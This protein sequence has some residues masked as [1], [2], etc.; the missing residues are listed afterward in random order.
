MRWIIVLM[1]IMGCGIERVEYGKGIDSTVAL[2][3]RVEVEGGGSVMAPYCTGV[4]I[5]E[6]EIITAKHCLEGKRGVE[7]I[8]REDM[9]G[10]YKEP[11]RV[12]KGRV[13]YM[14]RVDLGI[15]EVD[16]GGDWVEIGEEVGIGEGVYVVGHPRGLYWTLSRCG[17]SA[18]R[19][20]SGEGVIQVE[21]VVWY[22]NSGGGVFD[23]GGRLLGIASRLTEVPGMAYFVGKEDMEE[24]IRESRSR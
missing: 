11:K 1:L 24:V 17:V 18:Y 15:I 14:G 2:V 8:E 6:K 7:Y 13:V 4:R 19:K 16:E 23:R 3:R 21:G 12:R 9:V 20:D 22:G 5:S 10:V